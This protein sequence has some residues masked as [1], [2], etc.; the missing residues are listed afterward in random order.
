MTGFKI[1]LTPVGFGSKVEIDGQDVTS[2]I[3]GL[4][5]TSAVGSP[6]EIYLQ[7]VP[8]KLELEGDGI[9]HVL[10]SGSVKKFLSG[11]D[12]NVVK[13]M[14]LESMGWDEGDPLMAVINVIKHLG[15]EFDGDQS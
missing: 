4:N 9:I 2:Q 5:I 12:P 6:T 13:A 1:N 10:S 15:D 3:M 8:G 7:M 11:L 14:A